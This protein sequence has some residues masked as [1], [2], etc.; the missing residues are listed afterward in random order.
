MRVSGAFQYRDDKVYVWISLRQESAELPI[1]SGPIK[2]SVSQ[3]SKV[4][5]EYSEIVWSELPSPTYQKQ[6]E[7]GN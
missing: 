7:I 1:V 4:H 3:W 6:T 5:R 2:Y